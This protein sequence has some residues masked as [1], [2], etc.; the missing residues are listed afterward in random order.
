[1]VVRV[2]V[3]YVTSFTFSPYSANWQ[4]EPVHEIVLTVGALVLWN[5]AN[6]LISTISDGE[7]RVRDVVIGSAYSLW[8]YALIALLD[9]PLPQSYACNYGGLLAQRSIRFDSLAGPEGV[10][11]GRAAWERSYYGRE[12]DALA[13]KPQSR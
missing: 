10:G 2:A 11:H 6:Y 12:L 3:L 7:G 4:I 13:A 1:M 5:A 8:P 9:L